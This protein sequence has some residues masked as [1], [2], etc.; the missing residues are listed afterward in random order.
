MRMYRA[1]VPRVGGVADREDTERE[2]RWFP[3]RP[4]DGERQ[5]AI[6]VDEGDQGLLRHFLQLVLPSIFPILKF[7]EYWFVSS[8]LILLELQNNQGYLHC[9]LS[10]AAQHY[11]AT[12]GVQSEDIDNDVI[13][14]RYSAISSLH[15][16]LHK[17]ENHQQTLETALSLI[18]FQCFPTSRSTSTS[19]LPSS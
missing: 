5:V 16:A 19:R 4:Y 15:D 6:E 14:H 10:I 1:S 17:D 18:F 12:M 7:N 2:L 3:P 8:G 11:K 9:C 13:R